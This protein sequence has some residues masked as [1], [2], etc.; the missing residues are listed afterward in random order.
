[1]MGQRLLCEILV[2]ADARDGVA[3]DPVRQT[4]STF[5]SPFHSWLS[6]LQESAGTG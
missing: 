3:P 1:M 6:S 5:R 4:G 2:L